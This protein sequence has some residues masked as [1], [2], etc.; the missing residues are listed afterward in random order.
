MIGENFPQALYVFLAIYIIIILVISILIQKYFVRKGTNMFINIFC[1]FIWFTTMTM[2]LIFPLD[3]LSNFFFKNN[4]ETQSKIF[5]LFLYWVFYVCGFLIV[6]QL[7]SYI[8]NGNFTFI[9]KIISIIKFMAIFLLIFVGIGFILKLLL[10]LCIYLLGENNALSISLNIINTIIN[11]PMLI[12]Y[13]MFLGCGLWEVPKDLFIKYY[14]PLRIKKLCWEITHVM[15]KYR[16][17]TEFIIISI[18]KIKLTQEKIKNL[19][20]TDLE[21]QIKEAKKIMNL[22]NDKKLKKEKKE[23]YDNLNGLK[24]LYK[25]NKE[26]NEMLKKLENT[27]KIFNLVTN[28]SNEI[29]EL[30]NKKELVDINAKYKIYRGQIFRINYQKYS[31]YK[32]WAEIK[33]YIIQK[34]NDITKNK[35]ENISK[36]NKSENDK[37]THIDKSENMDIKKSDNNLENNQNIK[38][39]LS[40]TVNQKNENEKEIINE[41]NANKNMDNSDNEEDNK[42]NEIIKKS[43]IIENKENRNIN[44]INN[45]NIDLEFKVFN[46]TKKQIFYYRFMPIINI[47]FLLLCLVYDIFIIFGEV[48]YTF[49]WEI[50]AGKLLRKMFSNYYII[51]PIRIF[52]MYFTFIVVAYS[53]GNIKS[54]ITLCIYGNQQTEPCHM[55]FFVGMLAKLICPLCFNFI[56]IMYNGIDLKGNNSKISLYFEEQFGFLNSDHVVI[57]IVKIILLFLFLKAFVCTASGCYANYAYKKHK[58]LSFNANY[59]GKD[60]EIIMGDLILN[61]FNRIYGNNLEQLKAENITEYVKKE[62]TN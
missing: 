32:E 18:N 2:M 47:L 9:T 38:K 23:I 27:A 24:E 17:E 54:D 19:N 13:I 15:K 59:K 34:E 31:I 1:V 61:N 35:I 12:A 46:L 60:T 56:E 33:S 29:K 10:K 16:D 30:K 62:S 3:L 26:M 6:D 14:Y 21:N 39:C 20:I 53:L 37:I 4:E 51:T 57:Y 8:S 48:E 44:N 50:F 11:M 55:L 43:E 5:S 22:E 25:C 41:D 58:Y 28:I 7:K 40:L 36:N 42:N 49:G 52:P 45:N